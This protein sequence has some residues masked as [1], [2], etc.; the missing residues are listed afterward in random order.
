MNKLNCVAKSFLGHTYI[1]NKMRKKQTGG[2]YFFGILWDPHALF[3]P[4][5]YFFRILVSVLYVLYVFQTCYRH[6]CGVFRWFT[7]QNGKIDQI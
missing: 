7:D 6:I 2:V 3:R 5:V 1:A 4:P